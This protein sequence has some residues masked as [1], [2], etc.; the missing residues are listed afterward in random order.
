MTTLETRD[1]H[2]LLAPSHEHAW[3]TESSHPTSEG[4]VR[5]VRCVRCGDRRV[6]IQAHSDAPPRPLTATLGRPAGVRAV[7]PSP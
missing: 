6:D 4:L 1:D 2:P 3:T 7:R 5:Y